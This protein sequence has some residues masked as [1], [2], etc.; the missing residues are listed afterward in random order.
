MKIK[1][2]AS[3]G[4]MQSSDLMVVVEPADRLEIRDRVHREEA[5]RATDPRENR[6]DARAP[7]ASRRDRS[8]S[9]IGAPSTMR[10]TPVSKRPCAAQRRSE[11]RSSSGIA[12]AGRDAGSSFR[13]CPAPTCSSNFCWFAR[14]V[15]LKHGVM[16]SAIGSVRNVQFSDIQAGAR[17][18]ITEPR[19]PVHRSRGRSTCSGSRETSCRTRTGRMDAAPAHLRRRSRRAK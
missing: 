18:P 7:W 4:T 13:S 9:R 17:L 5:V 6:G 2:K 8:R 16:L 19:M 12:S 11:W 3:A 1:R 10:S 15:G 14:T